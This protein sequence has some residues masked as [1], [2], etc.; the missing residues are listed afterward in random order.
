MTSKSPSEEYEILEIDLPSNYGELEEDEPSNG[1]TSPNGSDNSGVIVPVERVRL[2]KGFPLQGRRFLDTILSMGINKTDAFRETDT[3]IQA[4]RDSKSISSLIRGLI[5]NVSLLWGAELGFFK[6][7]SFEGEEPSAEEFRSALLTIL[8]DYNRG[9]VQIK[10]NNDG[11]PSS[12]S[13]CKNEECHKSGDGGIYK[14]ALTQNP[15]AL[16]EWEDILG[17]LTANRF[18]LLKRVCQMPGGGELIGHLPDGRLVFKSRPNIPVIFARDKKGNWGMVSPDDPDRDEF[19][20]FIDKNGVFANCEETIELLNKMGWTAPV[21]PEDYHIRGLVSATEAVTKKP[22]IGENFG[23]AVLFPSVGNAESPVYRVVTYFEK[24]NATAVS[25]LR[26]DDK[27]P[28][29][30]IP[31]LIG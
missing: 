17:K 8:N 11:Q 22:F 24:Y 14:E 1:P 26:P 6:N 18:E 9:V 19:L 5:N 28:V 20:K 30:A 13:E 7:F 31:F 4:N 16:I 15:S 27:K 3:P 10:M 21:D 12:A 23:R 29:G 25:N 2:T